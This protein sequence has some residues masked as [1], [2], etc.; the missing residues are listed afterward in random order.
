MLSTSEWAQENF[1]DC[2][3]GDKRRVDRLIDVA[4]QV[5]SNPSGS[6]PE[7]FPEWSELSAEVKEPIIK[8]MRKFL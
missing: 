4:Q 8:E 6:L 7:Q 1:C 5:V 2:D 3:L